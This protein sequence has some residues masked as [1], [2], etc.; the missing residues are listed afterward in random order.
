[1]T[2]WVYLGQLS[3]VPM[4][5]SKLKVSRVTSILPPGAWFIHPHW[6]SPAVNAHHPG[7]DIT[8]TCCCQR[9]NVRLPIASQFELPLIWPFYSTS[10][11]APQRAAG[12]CVCMRTLGLHHRHRAAP[13][14]G[15]SSTSAPDR[16]CSRLRWD[17]ADIERDHTDR[18]ASRYAAESITEGG[19]WGFIG[20]DTTRPLLT[21][22]INV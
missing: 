5:V 9:S 1:M 22:G 16:R 15:P 8:L 18:H 14:W 13:H 6:G 19:M 17:R 2:Q 20:A 12:I 7:E 21:R 11:D 4:T 10:C 3:S